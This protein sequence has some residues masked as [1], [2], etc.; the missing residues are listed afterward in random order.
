MR[1]E[2]QLPR[3]TL[4]ILMGL[5]E[6]TKAT[7]GKI[8]LESHDDAK[9]ISLEKTKQRYNKLPNDDNILDKYHQDI[10]I[11]LKNYEYVVVDGDC[12]NSRTRDNFFSN[13][14]IPPGTSMIGV[15]ID[16]SLTATLKANESA[17]E[18][19]RK[20]DSLVREMF[21]IKDS[22]SENERFDKLIY[23]NID[24]ND[25][26]AQNT[27]KITNVIEQLKTI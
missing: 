4:I 9:L 10:S 5:S 8:I 3:H 16:S 25:G 7:L 14:T 11:A 19:L 12:L 1:K 21:K 15:W 20:P 24:D 17:P 13:I 27:Q 18:G 6:T 23:L 26:F 2:K 22:P